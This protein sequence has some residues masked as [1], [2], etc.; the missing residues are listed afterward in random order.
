MGKGISLRLDLGEDR[1]CVV[2]REVPNWNELRYFAELGDKLT[3]LVE[4]K[5]AK[6]ADFDSVGLLHLRHVFEH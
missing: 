1:V 4:V 2:D 6:A 5:R 3:T